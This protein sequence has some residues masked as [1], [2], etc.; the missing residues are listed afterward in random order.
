MSSHSPSI[1]DQIAEAERE[2]AAYS[3]CLVHMEGAAAERAGG[4]ASGPGSAAEAARDEEECQLEEISRLEQERDQ[5]RYG[6]AVHMYERAR[7]VR[8]AHAG[9]LAVADS[10]AAEAG[11]LGRFDFPSFKNAGP[12]AAQARQL[13]AKILP[14][15]KHVAMSLSS[16][17]SPPSLSSLS[18]T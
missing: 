5:E 1:R 12:Y 6:S 15:G 11:P 10:G 14:L 2:I 9:G 4:G 17:S 18:A 13:A 7:G 8:G 16:A 3:A